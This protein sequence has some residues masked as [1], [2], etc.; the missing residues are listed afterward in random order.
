MRIGWGALMVGMFLA[1]LSAL[2]LQE[3]RRN[4]EIRASQIEKQIEEA[5]LLDVTTQME[6][7]RLLATLQDARR[8]LASD[9]EKAD[10]ILT[11]LADQ[12]RLT[13]KSFAKTLVSLDSSKDRSSPEK[14]RALFWMLLAATAWF[15]VG[16]CM[17]GSRL[18]DDLYVWRDPLNWIGYLNSWLSWAGV[19]ILTPFI[20][21]M[22]HRFPLDRSH[23]SNILAHILGCML[24]WSL[25]NGAFRLVQ[26]GFHQWLV[27]F[28]DALGIGLAWGFKFD[29]YGAVLLAAIALTNLEMKKREELRV[30]RV[31]VMFVSAQLEALRM[32]LHPH[33]LFN[34]LN[35]IIELIHQNPRQAAELLDRLEQFFVMTLLIDGVQDVSLRKELDFVE[36]YL[37]MQKV[38]FPKRLSVRM[39]IDENSMESRV[40]VLILQPLI[41]N[42][43]RHGIAQNPRPGEIS[44]QSRKSDGALHLK[45]RDTGPGISNPSVQEGIGL[46]NT[47]RRLQ[48]MY[49]NEFRFEIKN[50]DTGGLLV[51]LEIPSR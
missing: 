35:S 2:K 14:P 18:L 21:W 42:A 5:K 15:L 1:F 6:P 13:L 33:F 22:N 34:A 39:E 29:V 37:E 23:R 30:A 4:A 11:D 47:K 50:E 3:E 41:E 40:P 7:D 31:E 51:S 43:V 28:P 46:A 26:D 36:C 19:A 17:A 20:F 24:F 44:I 32:Q 25:I 38:R 49:G 12:L 48:H 16:I 9:P 10:E 27:N 45:I 8:T